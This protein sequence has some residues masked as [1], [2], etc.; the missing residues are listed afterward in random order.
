MRFVL[1][2]HQQYVRAVVVA[3][4]DNDDVFDDDDVDDVYN[5]L[6]ADRRRNKHIT[7]G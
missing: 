3:V 5:S 2:E 6:S 7:R 1:G 4:A